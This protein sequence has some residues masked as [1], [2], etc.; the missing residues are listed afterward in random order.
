MVNPGKANWE[1]LKW[2]L[3]YLRGSTKIDL[4][5]KKQ[6]Y[7]VQLVVGYVDSDFAGNLD[8][9]KSL[10]G[11]VFTVFGITICCKAM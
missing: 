10:T 2:I 3:R 5:F 1:A 7:M 8:T 9:M 11:F 6:K 4:L